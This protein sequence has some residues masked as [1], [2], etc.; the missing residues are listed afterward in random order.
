MLFSRTKLKEVQDKL[1]VVFKRPDLL[2]LAFTHRSYLNE[3]VRTDLQHNERLEFLG[4]AV[5]E[6]AITAYLYRRLPDTPEGKM[7]GIRSALVSGKSLSGIAEELGFDKFLLLSRGERKTFD[8]HDRGRVYIMA[9]TF[10]A[11]LGA[12]YLDRGIGIV[13]IFLGS[14]FFPRLQK[15][16]TEQLDLDP[17][18]CLQDVAQ[19]TWRITPFYR[20]VIEEGP[21]HNRRFVSAV[22][23][24]EENVG[25][26]EGKSKA[27]AEVE[28]ARD[29]LQKKF[30]ITLARL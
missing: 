13:E 11:V 24:G 7:T 25:E 19:S 2:E 5:L 20:L 9:N 3:T 14:C 10:E 29:A 28:A 18:S 26:G 1:G 23:I 16:I 22:Y 12:I 27:E 30:N 8:N 21:A 15:V 17:K 4:D 6:L